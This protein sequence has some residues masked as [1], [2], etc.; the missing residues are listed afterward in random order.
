MTIQEKLAT[1]VRTMQ[2]VFAAMIV[3]PLVFA[4]VVYAIGS[5]APQNP[6][7]IRGKVVGWQGGPVI[8]RIA[9]GTGLVAVAIGPWIGRQVTRLARVNLDK[10]G[11]NEPERIAEAHLTGQ[12]VTGATNEM[13]AFMNLIGYMATQSPWCLAMGLLLILSNAVRFP[14]MRQ[15]VAWAE[16]RGG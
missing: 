7:P 14:T 15:A 2:I 12:V 3:V 9:L 4:G 16:A 5:Q 13:A 1:Q 10:Q 6:A 11:L 8:E